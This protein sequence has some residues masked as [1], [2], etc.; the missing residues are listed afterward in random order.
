[1]ENLEVE[2]GLKV[3][4]RLQQTMDLHP[5]S[6]C[7]LIDCDESLSSTCMSDL[8]QWLISDD[9]AGAAGGLLCDLVNSSLLLFLLHCPEGY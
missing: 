8:F 5:E 7:T 1:M 6:L 3:S 9:T 4:H 2:E